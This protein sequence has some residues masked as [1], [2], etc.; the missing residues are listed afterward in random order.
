M[1]NVANL[2]RDNMPDCRFYIRGLFWRRII[3]PPPLL[4]TLDPVFRIT[5]KNKDIFIFQQDKKDATAFLCNDAGA[6]RI[7]EDG[8]A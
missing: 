7:L 1:K 6:K 5:H 4:A 2:L 8:A 3:V